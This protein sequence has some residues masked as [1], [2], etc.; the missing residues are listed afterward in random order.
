M[1]KIKVISFDLHETLATPAF[2][3]AVW[4]EGIPHIYAERRRLTF[5]R[6]KEEVFRAYAGVDENS[7]E[8]FDLNYW[9]KELDLGGYQGAIDF[10]RHKVA[11]YPETF[12]VL[13]ALKQKYPLIIASSM[14]REFMP[15]I[16]ERLDPYFTRVFSSYSDYYQFKCSDFYVTVCREMGIKP[17][18]MAHVGDNW[19]KDYEYPKAVGVKAIHLDRKGKP[20]DCVIT[21]LWQLEKYI[22][23]MA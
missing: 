18:E 23:K 13:R 5:D 22:E 1:G 4:D 11:Y 7:R 19:K 14:P 2:A 20:G 16:L 15:P 17:E 10:C 9:S 3:G 12:D 21:D 6:A 8:F